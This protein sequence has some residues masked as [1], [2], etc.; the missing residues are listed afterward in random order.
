MFSREYCKIFENTYFEEHLRTA[1]SIFS[2]IGE[3]IIDHTI[4]VQENVN[5]QKQLLGKLHEISWKVATK[6]IHFSKVKG[7][8]SECLIKDT[9]PR[10]LL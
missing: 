3:S 5:S 7:L 10:I 8:Q 6:A 1:A 4:T 9:P 2:V